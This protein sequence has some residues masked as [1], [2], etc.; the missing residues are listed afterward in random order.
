MSDDLVDKNRTS[1]VLCHM[2]PAS[3]ISRANPFPEGIDPYQNVWTVI[4]TAITT[5]P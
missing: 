2:M 5:M 1:C 4:I 3:H